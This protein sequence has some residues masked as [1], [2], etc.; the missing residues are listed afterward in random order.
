M[1]LAIACTSLASTAYLSASYVIFIPGITSSGLGFITF[2]CSACSSLIEALL[3]KL[4]PIIV[5]TF[6]PPHNN[7]IIAKTP[8]NIFKKLFLFE[9]LFLEKISLLILSS[10]V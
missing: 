9:F 2:S 6:I 10:Y 8:K 7:S 5:T 4:L 1:S 3:A